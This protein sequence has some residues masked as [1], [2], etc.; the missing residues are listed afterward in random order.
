MFIPFLV[1]SQ[2]KTPFVC[3]DYQRDAEYKQ[4]LTFLK[5]SEKEGAVEVIESIAA[6][7]REYQDWET[8]IEY[9]EKLIED[10]PK[11][12]YYFSLGVAAARKSLEVPQFR[13]VPYIVKARKSVLKAH[14]MEPENVTFLNLLIPLNA[15]IPMFF[16][17]SYAFAEQQCK[18]LKNLDPLS[19]TIMQ[20]YLYEVREMYSEAKSE[21][22]QVFTASE[23]RISSFDRGGSQLNRD[24]LF[25]LGRAAAQHK[26]YFELG[27]RAMDLYIDD[28]GRRDN[29]PLAWAHFY[30]AKIYFYNDQLPKAIKSLHQALEINP[31]FEECL[32]F[33]KTIEDE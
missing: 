33:L 12:E 1:F 16:G 6:L 28:Y 20:A 23:N 22:I 11:A 17:G 21:F 4:Q 5:K 31:N 15:E 2:F 10:Y 27:G 7:S 9:Y 18:L 25:K 24:Q 13:S 8:A 14:E 30:R 19:G 3:C 32:A 29:Y 26:I